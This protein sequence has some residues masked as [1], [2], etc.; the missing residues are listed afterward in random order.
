MSLTLLILQIYDSETDFLYAA[1]S[2]KSKCSVLANKISIIAINELVSTIVPFP[3]L[4][5]FHSN[6]IAS[7]IEREEKL[8]PPSP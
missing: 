5:I 3:A 8:T 4:S 2:S 1:H 6:L 7:Q